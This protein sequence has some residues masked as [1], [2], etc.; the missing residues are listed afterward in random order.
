MKENG[1]EMKEDKKRDFSSPSFV[2]LH[3][4]EMTQPG[5]LGDWGNPWESNPCSCSC[6]IL[7]TDSLFGD[8]LA[9]TEEVVD[10]LN[11][12]TSAESCTR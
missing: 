4:L 10:K 2:Q 3:F 8:L 9:Q 5:V 6:W 11:S 1:K 7:M 12:G